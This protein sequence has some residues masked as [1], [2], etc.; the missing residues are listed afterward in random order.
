MARKVLILA[1]SERSQVPQSRISGAEI[2]QTIGRES[3]VCRTAEA[4]TMNSRAA[5]PP[6]TELKRGQPFWLRFN[7]RR[8]CGAGDGS[9]RHGALLD[10]PL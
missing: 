9:G 4:E 10:R 6:S 3:A 5:R 1:F 8:V 7:N 2:L